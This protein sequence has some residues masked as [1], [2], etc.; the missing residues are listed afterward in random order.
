VTLEELKPL[1]FV[2]PD[3]VRQM[4]Q[5]AREAANL[6]VLK[7]GAQLVVDAWWAHDKCNPANEGVAASYLITIALDVLSHH[8]TTA[9][10]IEFSDNFKLTFQLLRYVWERVSAPVHVSDGLKQSSQERARDILDYIFRNIEWQVVTRRPGHA[11]E[12]KRY[13]V[14][15]AR[16]LLLRSH[17]K[18]TRLGDITG[19]YQDLDSAIAQV[20]IVSRSLL[21]YDRSLLT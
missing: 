7:A 11:L 15:H 2:P 4:C 18:L 1:G 21:M 14:F 3:T 16:C 20:C 12:R 13:K 6:K 17:D 9:T 8:G 5:Q 19:A 10:G